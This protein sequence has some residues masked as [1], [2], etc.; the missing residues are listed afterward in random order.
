MFR[1][2]ILICTAVWAAASFSAC[3]VSSAS[4]EIAF[5]AM[6]TYMTIT[7]YGD[8]AANA[9]QAA[10]DEI[11]RLDSL[12][13]TEDEG[14]EVY[15]LNENGSGTLS[16]D[17][18]ALIDASLK[19]WEATDG[20]FDISV[21]PV[22][23]LWGFAGGEYKVPDEKELEDTLALV[24][25]GKIVWDEESGTVTLAEG[26][27]ID[28]GG[29]AKGY[30]GDAITDIFEEYGVTG[31]IASLGG[32]IVVYGEKTDSTLWNVAIEDPEDMSEYL[33][34][35]SIEDGVSVVTSGGYERYFEED[36]VTYHHIIDPD[37]G[38]PADSGLISVTI[39]S[40]NGTEA[41]GL[42]TSMFVM[43]KDEAVEFWKSNE[44]YDFEM[45][46]MD[47]ERNLY[48]TEGLSG[49]FSSDLDFEIITGE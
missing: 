23:E 19:L 25:A 38:Y 49:S 37:T 8:N 46:L 15:A 2:I 44:A 3:G 36:G 42:S 31:A 17:S 27:A 35:L 45:I 30:A 4:E 22:M 32:N 33:G 47:S 26:M 41:D 14:S 12:L 40:E 48:V 43:G 6:D 28:F 7:V 20:A 34:V 11:E 16:E 24:D 29:I 9:A 39:A 5:E 21:Y 13:S 10:K 1:K 18:T